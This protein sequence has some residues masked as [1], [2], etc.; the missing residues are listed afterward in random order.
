[1]TT[2]STSKQ[3]GLWFLVLLCLHL[4][5]TIGN[6][7]SQHHHRRQRQPYGGY[8][9][10]SRDADDALND[11]TPYQ[12]SS[13]RGRDTSRRQLNEN[14]VNYQFSNRQLTT[15]G[16]EQLSRRQLRKQQ[17]RLEKQAR[18]QVRSGEMQS[19][20]NKCHIWVP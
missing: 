6:A 11:V 7:E 13:Y 12:R 14:D 17:Q 9:A 5:V 16:T 18:G 20:G 15:S 19:E 2:V 1:M 4:V 10:D 3:F 8:A